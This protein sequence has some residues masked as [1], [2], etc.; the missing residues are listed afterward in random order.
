MSDPLIFDSATPR[1][2]L[3]LLYAGQTQKEAFVNEALE[4]LDGLLHC[5]ILG[6]RTTP[7]ATANDGDTWIVG[8]TATGDWTGHDDALAVRQGSGWAFITPRDGIRVY[9]QAARQERFFAGGWKKAMLPM[10]LLGGLTV[11]GEARA[12]INDLVSALQALG[13]FPKA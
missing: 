12:A 4:R 1:F 9:D 11:D 7:P 10:E 13:I 8:S 2:G 5:A 3:P 6:E